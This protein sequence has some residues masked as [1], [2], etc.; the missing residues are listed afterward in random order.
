V[1][2]I[3]VVGTGGIGSRHLQGLARLSRADARIIGVEPDTAARRL[4]RARYDEVARPDSPPLE[5]AGGVADLPR[6]LDIAV[7]ATTAPA[8]AEV[9]AALLASADVRYLVL[10]KFLFQRPEEYERTAQL[11]RRR[12]V[13]CWVNLPRP[14]QT[15][16]QVM[17][18]LVGTEPATWSVSG[19][20]WGLASN[21]VHL[22][23]RFVDGP[24]DAL[25][26]DHAGLDGRTVPAKRAGFRE[27]T[28]T[29][30]GRAGATSFALEDRPGRPGGLEISV[31]RAGG[32][33][34]LH[35][36]GDHAE[37]SVHDA[38]GTTAT[39]SHHPILRQSELTGRIARELLTSGTC[40]LPDYQRSA[41]LHL[42]VLDALMSHLDVTGETEW[43]DRCPIT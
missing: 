32:H 11:L 27:F 14:Y 38:D 12:A 22:V 41:A 42:A 43:G 31:E 4:A 24:L 2:C 40:Q 26:L 19:S 33:L 36:T 30:R 37:L 28:G 9:T 5:W 1:N 21:A 25:E 15:V 10:E 16:W 35:E 39:C 20:S 7:V 18:G 8:R 34:R 23:E 6:A 29:L 13:P 3:T 17:R